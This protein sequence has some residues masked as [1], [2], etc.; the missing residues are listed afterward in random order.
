[1][2]IWHLSFGSAEREDIM[3]GACG[4]GS[5]SSLSN[6]EGNNET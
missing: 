5:D 4:R 6:Q 2:V 1:M 3:L